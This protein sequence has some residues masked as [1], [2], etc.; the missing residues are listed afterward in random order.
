[1]HLL[2][3]LRHIENAFEI[4]VVRESVQYAGGT[5]SL[6]GNTGVNDDDDEYWVGLF[7]NADSELQKFYS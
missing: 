4:A 6:Y 5:S 7:I 1:M 3:I 2:S